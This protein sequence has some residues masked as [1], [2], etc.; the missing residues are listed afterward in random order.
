MDGRGVVRQNPRHLHLVDR[1]LAA[2]IR[3]CVFERLLLHEG[4]QRLI[5]ERGVL[6]EFTDAAIMVVAFTEFMF[7]TLSEADLVSD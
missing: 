4:R 5:K 7:N 3:N 1:Q 2:S 6:H